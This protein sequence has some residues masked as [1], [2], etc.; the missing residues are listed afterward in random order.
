MNLILELRQN[1]K[2]NKDFAASDNIREQLKR[3]GI[4]VKDTKDGASWE[5]GLKIDSAD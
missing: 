3:L 2:A 4:V 1:A 5:Y